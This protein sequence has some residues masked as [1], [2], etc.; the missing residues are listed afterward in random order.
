MLKPSHLEFTEWV[1]L[2][3]LTPAWGAWYKDIRPG[4]LKES[5]NGKRTE[6]FLKMGQ[7][8]ESVKGKQQVEWVFKKI[9]W[10]VPKS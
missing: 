7:N 6:Q 3:W 10:L 1:L 4:Q 2:L 8:E 9:K 5:R